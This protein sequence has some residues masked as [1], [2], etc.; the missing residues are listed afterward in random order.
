MSGADSRP[1]REELAADN[2]NTGWQWFP[3][4][5][6]TRTSFAFV[7]LV[8][9]ALIAVTLFIALAVRETV[10]DRE[11][12]LR[13]A[14]TDM[15]LSALGS[16]AHGA[17]QDV[18][19]LARSP[20]ASDLLRGR[21]DPS[22]GGAYPRG[23]QVLIDHILG[24]VET[25]SAYRQCRLI[26]AQGLEALRIERDGEQGTVDI[27]G[28]EDLQ[29]KG[30]RDYVRE[31][32]AL[33]EGE[34]YVSAIELNREFGR[35]E[36]PS[37]P[38]LRIA[39]PIWSE[40]LDRAVGLVILN[41]DMTSAF[42]E[43]RQVAVHGQRLF[44]VNERGEF[45]LHPDREREF[46]FEY[47]RPLGVEDEFHTPLRDLRTAQI[48]GADYIF[49]L[50]RGQLASGPRVTLLIAHLSESVL[51]PA[52]VVV[53]ASAIAAIPVLLASLV[54]ALLLSRSLA[55]PIEALT[56]AARS[57]SGS[58][59]FAVPPGS[60]EEIVVLSEALSQM[61]EEVAANASSLKREIG[62]RQLAEERFR[63]AVEGSPNGILLTDAAGTIMLVNAEIER[64]FGFDRN[65][66]LGQSVECLIPPSM[67]AKHEEHR[68][69]FHAKPTQ[70]QMGEGRDLFGVRKDG[71]LV[72][73]EIGLNPL[74]TPEG[75]MVL[76]TI[77][78]ITEQRKAKDRLS[79]Y[80]ARLEQSNA[81]LERFAYVVSHDLKSPLRGMANVAC[82][83]LDD[84]EKIVDEEAREN[85]SLMVDRADR[86]TRLID[87]ILQY[88]RVTRQA[89]DPK[90]LDSGAVIAGV[91]ESLDHSDEVSVRTEGAFPEIVYD[92][93][94]FQQVLLNL[95]DNAIRHSARPA[96]EV[97][98]SCEEVDTA[99]RFS[100][101]DNGEGIE[102]RHFER[103]FGLFQTLSTSSE[104]RAAGI[105]LTIVKRIVERNGGEVEVR[106][107][108][109]KGA[110]FRFSV[111]FAAPVSN[112]HAILAAGST[113]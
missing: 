15:A 29:D 9:L 109:G 39:S 46:G 95:I 61:M 28:G 48:D 62:E 41:V 107:L 43:L 91:I 102:K 63:R 50:S 40:S 20:V 78:D 110:E 59:R 72:P 112:V 7:T 6:R 99:W 45:L 106:S 92:E 13:Q 74:D 108:V 65:E 36:D 1:R 47:G 98:I 82:W 88:S 58:D 27:V 111:P 53:R 90:P 54:V 23:E 100:V 103:I 11:L 93:T 38:V 83:L 104:G 51:A 44:L 5:L 24:M 8:L 56:A 86:L 25:K 66:L 31:T 60:S 80:A 10:L 97:V 69:A 2:A 17:R 52:A 30:L 105:G 42:A 85:L 33:E 12:A 19:A 35:V 18:L 101:R 3:S 70:R 55:R 16:H 76:A 81:E 49:T 79:S 71:E 87:G 14:S 89:I 21:I 77:V 94:Q 4:R 37:W 64:L 75:V 67:H 68:A 34:V 96:G 57:R 84:L 32:L 113:T 26:D 22:L 73:V